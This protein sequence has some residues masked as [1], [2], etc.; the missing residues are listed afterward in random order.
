MSVALESVVDPFGERTVERLFPLPV[1]LDRNEPQLVLAEFPELG[2][3][4]SGKYVCL[5]Q[6]QPPAFPSFRRAAVRGVFF[7]GDPTPRKILLGD[8]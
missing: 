8:S 4:P 6:W 7:S 3:K 1:Q 2:T 5:L